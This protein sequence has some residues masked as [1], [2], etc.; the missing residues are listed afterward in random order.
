MGLE[1]AHMYGY[2]LFSW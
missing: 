2:S 1:Y